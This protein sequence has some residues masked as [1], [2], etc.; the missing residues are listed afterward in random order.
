MAFNKKK[1]NNGPSPNLSDVAMRNNIRISNP[2][3]YYPD[4]VDRVIL[5]LENLIN[6]LQAE[7]Q[8]LEREL[9]STSDE[10]KTARATIQQLKLDMMTFEPPDTSAEEDIAMIARLSSIN[11]NVGTLEHEMPVISENSESRIPLDVIENPNNSNDIMF[12]NLVTN[13]ETNVSNVRKPE[14]MNENNAGIYN[15]F[16]QLDIL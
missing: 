14:N 6:T 13:N 7:T 9:A 2:Y 5:K 4:D 16:G 15:E 11:E 3:G 1:K 12:D 10:L 8:K